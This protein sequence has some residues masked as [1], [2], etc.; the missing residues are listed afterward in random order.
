MNTY[1]ISVNSSDF[2]EING[3]LARFNGFAKPTLTD[4]AQKAKRFETAVLA[5]VGCI[6]MW[7]K[8][9]DYPD[10]VFS[11]HSLA[12]GTPELAELPP[13]PIRYKTLVK[14]ELSAEGWS[15]R[16]VESFARFQMK[17]TAD[18]DKYRCIDRNGIV[19]AESG[20]GHAV[21]DVYLQNLSFAMHYKLNRYEEQKKYRPKGGEKDK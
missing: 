16:S 11:V 19:V 21:T 1:I 10:I 15:T 17:K 13:L 14:P 2:P 18:G 6:H 12:S 5:Q 3:Y 4:D 20:D 7:E 9:G 8:L